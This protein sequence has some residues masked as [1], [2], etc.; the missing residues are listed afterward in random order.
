MDKEVKG[1]LDQLDIVPQSRDRRPRL[2]AKTLPIK[3]PPSLPEGKDV[4]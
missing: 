3:A 1:L 4:A 2:S